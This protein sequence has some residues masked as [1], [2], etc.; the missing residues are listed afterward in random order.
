MGIFSVIIRAGC[1]EL[2]SRVMVYVVR[3]FTFLG[4]QNKVDR[5]E[6]FLTKILIF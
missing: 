3:L 2:N 4:I 5:G 1:V 6:E